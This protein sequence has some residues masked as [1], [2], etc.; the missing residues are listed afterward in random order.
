MIGAIVLNGFFPF[1][2]HFTLKLMPNEIY[3]Q[4]PV[5]S[6]DHEFYRIISDFC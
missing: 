4:K 3:K 5:Y 2:L 6:A 1:Q